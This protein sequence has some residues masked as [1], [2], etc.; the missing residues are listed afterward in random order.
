METTVID[1]W[2]V[3]QL[4]D[5]FLSD[6]TA[7]GSHITDFKFVAKVLKSKRFGKAENAEKTAK[8]CGGKTVPVMVSVGIP[9]N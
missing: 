5:L 3:I 6:Y 8:A 4:G 1:S 7:Q 9:E 2:F